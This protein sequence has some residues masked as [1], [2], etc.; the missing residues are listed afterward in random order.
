MPKPFVK[1]TIDE[2]EELVDS[3]EFTRQIDAVH[4]HHTWKP[5]HSQYRGLQTIN[6]MWEYHTQTNGWSDIAQHISIAPD[7]SIWTGRNWNKPPASAAGYNGNSAKGPFMFEMIGNFDTGKDPFAD[8]QKASVIRVIEALLA[9]FSLPV[10]ALRF[11]N[12]MTDQKSCPGTAIDYDA[13]C[14]EIT[15]VRSST[16][17]SPGAAKRKAP[18][19]VVLE[20]LSR[21]EIPEEVDLG[22]P[23]YHADHL[24][25]T[26]REFNSRAIRGTD[27]SI[28]P[29][30]HLINLRAGRLSQSG[31]ATTSE[32]DL[33]AIFQVHLPAA[34]DEARAAARPLR[35]MFFAHGGLND[36]KGS[37]ETAIK[38]IPWWV[39][40]D[41]YPIFFIWETGLMET[42]GQMLERKTDDVWGK[43]KSIFGRR[44]AGE[45]IADHATD[46]AI[47]RLARA[48]GGVSI[49]GAMKDSAER[50]S[51]PN[52][53]GAWLAARH[54][55]D[56]LKTANGHPVE[57]HAVGHSAGS[58]F[59][60]HFLAAVT[61]ALGPNGPGIRTLHHLAPAIRV[62]L[63]KSKVLPL[64]GK[65]IDQL[66]LYTMTDVLEKRD[67]CMKVY[68]KSLLYLIHYGLEP[69]VRC[70]LIGLE[71][72]VRADAVL[73]NLFE[74]VAPGLAEVIWSTSQ[75]GPRHSSESCTHGGFDDDEM[76]MNSVCR[77]ILGRD[78]IQGYKV[79]SRHAGP[80]Q[81]TQEP[82]D[83]EIALGILTAHALRGQPEAPQTPP[84]AEK[85][86]DATTSPNIIIREGGKRLA[87]CVGIDTYPEERDRLNGCVN[88]TRR[89]QDYLQSI[90]FRTERML[91]GEATRKAILESLGGMV[92]SAKS[93]DLIVV[94]YA[95]H[96]TQVTDQSGDETDD[97]ADE[98][99]CCHD[100]RT[101]RLVLDDD[102]KDIILTLHP[103]AALNFFFDSCHSGSAT[104]MSSPT[105]PRVSK[106]PVNAVR[107]M[108]FAD[109]D[110][111][112]AHAAFQKELPSVISSTRSARKRGGGDPYDGATDI[113]FAAALPHQYAHEIH[114]GG[115]FT[116][117]AM[118]VLAGGGTFTNRSFMDAV[119]AGFPDSFSDSQSPELYCA[120]G[121][122][123]KP[124]LATSA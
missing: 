10:S 93:G 110:L 43:I 90:G 12:H 37:L 116:D 121:R 41:I 15:T 108:V 95:G 8:P 91:N 86:P 66:T 60:A 96:G 76:T 50:A 82:T 33:E 51:A 84:A 118:K 36:E 97:S 19:K 54:L 63:F 57:L 69:E 26:E 73:K 62:D 1:L 22:A 124:F 107:R 92:A 42:L 25:F 111:N 64:L 80:D 112:E 77:R 78:D 21:M 61:S 113:L 114:G 59:H 11:H 55:S 3:F 72:S 47:E 14:G 103:A 81:I 104:R 32:A 123:S 16:K 4:M 94:Q 5:D 2:F 101:G 99:L 35:I 115:V 28:R 67:T 79:G 119:K 31:S 23:E 38:R 9:K 120:S 48:V 68:G 109:R 17:R 20:T 53:G 75:G 87:L 6:S 56:F 117:T 13:F 102:L 89:W 40:N 106:V 74:P 83:E 70:P 39:K 7:G 44:G 29:E 34:L 46:P 85:L 58:I 65:G 98:A 30:A 52:T 49:W 122:K 45:F 18:S 88:D 105:G 27:S 100:F 24:H 71:Q